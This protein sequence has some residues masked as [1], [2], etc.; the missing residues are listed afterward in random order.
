V[1]FA[2]RLELALDMLKEQGSL[3][4]HAWIAGDDEMGR[5][6]SFRRELRALNE[7]YLLAVPS[8]SL[9]RDLEADPPPYSGHGT[10]PLNPF[11]RVDHW[12]KALPADAWIRVEVRDADKG[13][14]VMYV[15]QCRVLAITE[16]QHPESD[17]KLVVTRRIDEAGAT[18]HDYYLSSAPSTT[19]AAEFARVA[20][21]EHR[22][23]ECI[24]R[25]K[26]QAGL[27]DYETRTWQGWHHHQTL[28][29]LATWF[30]VQEAQR[31]KKELPLSLF[32]KSVRHWP[33]YSMPRPVPTMSIASRAIANAAWS[34]TN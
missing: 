9:I 1:K 19:P 21:A 16:R 29:L 2:T 23:E 6:T 20:N 8:N 24:K 14:L 13:P 12:R 31:G 25:A 5:S 22:I 26:S 3:L 33:N 32:H 15:A 34:E 4:P 7:R 30:L 17:E 27:S 10:R 28:S 18:V 11:V